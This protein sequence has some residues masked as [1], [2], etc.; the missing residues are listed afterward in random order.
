[1]VIEER[2]GDEPIV[3]KVT[4]PETLESALSA[5]EKEKDKERLESEQNRIW[6]AR[7]E[8]R[9]QKKFWEDKLAES[10][11]KQENHRMN[12]L[13]EHISGGGKGELPVNEGLEESHKNFNEEI[14]K[15]IDFYEGELKDL[16]R[17]EMENLREYQK[18]Q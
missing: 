16:N 8:A 15:K 13:R 1:M 10:K 7:G 18:H 5:E 17:Q 11:R 12:Q 9:V 2:F 14:Q 6:A 3:D 4:K